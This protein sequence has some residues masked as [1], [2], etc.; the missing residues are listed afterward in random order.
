MIFIFIIYQDFKETIR[1]LN[2]ILEWLYFLTLEIGICG[3]GL[4]VSRTGPW[5]SVL[6]PSKTGNAFFRYVEK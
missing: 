1:V 3:F 6:D 5:N 2:Y 4:H